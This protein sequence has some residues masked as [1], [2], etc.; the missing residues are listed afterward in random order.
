[1]HDRDWIILC[2]E[3]GP[4]DEV[5]Q[6]ANKILSEN[7]GRRAIIV[8]HAYLFRNNQRYDY[9][10]GHERASPHPWGN[11][12]EELWQK[13][14]KKHSNVMI[15]ISGHVATGGKGYRKDKGDRGN[16]VHQMMCD[17][18]KKEMGGLAYLR[19]LEFD[20]DGETVQVRTY[21]PYREKMQISSLEDFVFKLQ[22]APAAASSAN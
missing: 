14:I 17:Y 10:N 2:L 15:V 19:L 9:R 18:Q 22:D 20:P 12:G 5:V 21:S 16:V 8:T 13:L 4:R 1:M 7:R 11:D 6:W 3:M